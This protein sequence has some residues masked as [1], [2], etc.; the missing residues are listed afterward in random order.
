MGLY[1]KCPTAHYSDVIAGL[2]ASQITRVLMDYSTDCPGADKKISQLRVTGLCEGKSLVNS[3]N[4]GPVTRKM[5]SFDDVIMNKAL[6]E[7]NSANA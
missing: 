5:F 4:K 6:R 7:H 2:M 1:T 3:P